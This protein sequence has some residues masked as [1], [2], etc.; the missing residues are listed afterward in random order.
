MRVNAIVGLAR[1]LRVFR[2]AI[3]AEIFIGSLRF[4][5]RVDASSCFSL[6]VFAQAFR[7]NTRRRQGFEIRCG[8]FRQ[9]TKRPCQSGRRIA[10]QR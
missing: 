6:Q 8:N 10:H 7:N 2:R 9:K 5:S 4:L 1:G 3:D